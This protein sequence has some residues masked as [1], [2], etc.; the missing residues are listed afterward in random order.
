MADFVS[1]KLLMMNGGKGYGFVKRSEM[2][3]YLHLVM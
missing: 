1:P 2:E 3:P